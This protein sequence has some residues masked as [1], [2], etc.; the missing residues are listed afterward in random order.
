M[1]K[2]KYT[3]KNQK[4]A[5]QTRRRRKQCGG[6]KRNET[7]RVLLYKPSL[8]PNIASIIRVDKGKPVINSVFDL[9]GVFDT[10]RD[11]SDRVE[12]ELYETVYG[13]PKTAFHE[14]ITTFTFDDKETPKY[15]Y[16]VAKQFA[17]CPAGSG[18]S[19]GSGP[20]LPRGRVVGIQLPPLARQGA[21]SSPSLPSAPS[22]PVA[23][24]A[25]SA[26]SP[27]P[28]L[29]SALKGKGKQPLT[30]KSKRVNIRAPANAPERQSRRSGRAIKQVQLPNIGTTSGQTYGSL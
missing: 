27:S 15:V 3:R 18:T 11:S 30:Q 14:N 28:P 17:A 2:R 19:T 9:N 21:V 6:N 1:T 12:E 29:K 20:P 4:R 8:S 10:F 16:P 7:V 26:P 5:Q 23:R 13:Y 22:V 25:P 24:S